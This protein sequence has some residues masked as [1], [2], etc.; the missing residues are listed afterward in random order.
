MHASQCSQILFLFFFFLLLHRYPQ[1]SD[2]FLDEAYKVSYFTIPGK[3][4]PITFYNSYDL[5]Y[6]CV[7]H[8]SVCESRAGGEYLVVIRFESNLYSEVHTSLFPVII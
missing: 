7:E 5:G 6:T 2:T 1:I 4:A 3:N 8:S